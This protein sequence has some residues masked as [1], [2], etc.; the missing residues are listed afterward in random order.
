[1]RLT[2]RLGH[3][4]DIQSADPARAYLWD[5]DIDGAA[6]KLEHKLWLSN[7][8]IALIRFRHGATWKVWID[9]S[10][11]RPGSTH[12]NLRLSRRRAQAVA[13]YLS[14]ALTGFNV[15]YSVD[16]VGEYDARLARHPET[17]ENVGDRSVHVCLLLLSF[18]KPPPPPPPPPPPIKRPRLADGAAKPFRIR[19]LGA[20]GGGGNPL[21][22]GT[23]FPTSFKD[24]ARGLKP[25]LGVAV[26]NVYF[27]IL[28]V[29]ENR[30]AVYV[31]SGH[32]VSYGPSI[33]GIKSLGVTYAGDWNI[34]EVS[35][36][37]AVD[38]FGGA[39]RFFQAAANLA[40]SRSYNTFCFGGFRSLAHFLVEIKGFNTGVG[41]GLPAVSETGGKMKLKAPAAPFTDVAPTVR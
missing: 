32:G 39:A 14:S 9:G 25:G 11:S 37:H 5:F 36:P 29:V 38:D 16:W 21:Q 12:H 15:V 31:Y 18:S 13:D 30:H 8:I 20:Y 4:K 3:V 26:E 33:P 27:E 41:V 28:D 17:E 7:K 19:L 2:G 40:T 34:F 10:A 22:R 24:I 23:G 35:S 1:M 6:L